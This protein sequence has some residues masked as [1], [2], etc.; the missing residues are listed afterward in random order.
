M[1][2]TKLKLLTML[3]AF[4][5]NASGCQRALVYGDRTGFNLAVRTDPAK[6]DVLGVNAGLQRQ[7]VGFV[8]PQARN[9]EGRANSEAVNMI[10]RTDIRR[11]RAQDGNAFNDN[12]RI[13]SA[14]ISG[15][16]STEAKENPGLVSAVTA[17]PKFVQTD[18]VTDRAIN[19][20][21][22]NYTNRGNDEV[23]IYLDM[24]KALGLR[25]SDRS[26]PSASAI[27]TIFDPRNAVGN[28]KI[29]SDLNL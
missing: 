9:S 13:H 21:L 28:R 23:G 20:K 24:A 3:I 2:L 10:S 18:N 15:A 4:A 27:E 11:T 7:V 25:I 19:T 8:P 1:T 26:A 29:A 14:F 17:P 16:A 6:A 5:L 12:I 22:M